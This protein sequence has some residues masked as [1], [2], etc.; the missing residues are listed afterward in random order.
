MTEDEFNKAKDYVRAALTKTRLVAGRDLVFRDDGITI[1]DPFNGKHH[2]TASE[3]PPSLEALERAIV[4]PTFRSYYGSRPREMKISGHGT[5]NISEKD[6]TFR[7]KAAKNRHPALEA[8]TDANPDDLARLRSLYDVANVDIV[9]ACEG[10]VRAREI[11]LAF[12]SELNLSGHNT[13]LHLEPEHHHSWEHSRPEDAYEQDGPATFSAP[14]KVGQKWVVQL[15]SNKTV[16]LPPTH[17][18]ST[19]TVREDEH[20][21]R[22]FGR[23]TEGA[24]AP[25]RRPAVLVGV[26]LKDSTPVATVTFSTAAKSVASIS[27]RSNS[28]PWTLYN[29]RKAARLKARPPIAKT[30]HQ[31]TDQVARAFFAR[32]A[33]RGYVSGKSLY[34]HGPVAFAA[35]DR[36]PVAAMVDLPDGKTL[37][38]TGRA[39]GQSGTLAGSVSSAMNDID[40]AAR[41]TG[42]HEFHIG[43]L[44]D[45]LKLGDCELN[46][47]AAKL[48]HKKNEAEYPKS[49]AIDPSRLKTYITRRKKEADE[50]LEAHQKRSSV[51]TYTKAACWGQLERIATFRDAMVNLVGI[52]LPPMG[53]PCAYAEKYQLER[54][55]ALQRQNG[56]QDRR[57]RV[58]SSEGAAEVRRTAEEQR[59]GLFR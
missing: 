53:D 20:R 31:T 2:F 14:E 55:A 54:A 51:P 46:E 30:W 59:R 24:F 25:S 16:T 32:E 4:Q 41:D 26:T 18:V 58:A 12:A 9:V 29:D 19:I 56:L 50:E 15:L 38:F 23:A 6:G 8:V 22:Q 45:F 34:F 57:R 17:G 43:E 36:N 13:E 33:P 35:Y 3:Q 21:A 52:D 1:S 37:L 48:R 44:T 42:F 49:C 11:A 27:T 47:I 10:D 5:W 7:L 39:S 28:A 40:S